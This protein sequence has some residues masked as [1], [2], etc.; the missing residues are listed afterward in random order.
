MSRSELTAQQVRDSV[1]GYEELAIE[2][3]FGHIYEEI[4]QTRPSMFGRAL[5]FTLKRREGVVDVDAYDAVMK[6]SLQEV[7]DSFAEPSEEEEGKGDGPEQ[8]PEP[9][10]TSAS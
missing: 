3:K 7:S 2:E 6:M 4:A 8:Q 1:S 9:S 5:L 10:L